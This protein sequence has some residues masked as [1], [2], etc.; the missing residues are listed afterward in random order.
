MIIITNSYNNYIHREQ[1]FIILHVMY[2]L[3]DIMNFNYLRVYNYTNFFN[4]DVKY[5]NDL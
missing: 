2:F 3:L 5:L 4:R 1:N